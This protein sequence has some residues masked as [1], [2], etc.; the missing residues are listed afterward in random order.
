[1]LLWSPIHGPGS[2][3]W[4]KVDGGSAWAV[5]DQQHHGGDEVV[6]YG[7]EDVELHQ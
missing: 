1:M 5:T 4:V 2:V 7:P 3:R 6:G